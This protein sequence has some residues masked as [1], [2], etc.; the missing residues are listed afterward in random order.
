MCVCVCVCVCERERE[1][2]REREREGNGR[3]SRTRGH[4]VISVDSK[5]RLNLLL[6]CQRRCGEGAGIL[7]GPWRPQK[8]SHGAKAAAFP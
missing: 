5:D 3:A 2:G 7:S 1:R 6:F 8:P 4:A